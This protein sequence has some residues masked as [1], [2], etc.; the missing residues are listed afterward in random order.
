VTAISVA[1]V[2]RL[3]HGELLAKAT[4]VDWRVLMKRTW[5]LDVLRCPR[6]AKRLRVMATVTD[7]AAVGAILE[8]LKLPSM[9]PPRAP[10]GR[11]TWEQQ[12]FDVDVA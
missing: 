3:E 7:S 11:P 4:Y 12:G 10:P 6:C 1:H 8:H 2:C 9:P 5:G